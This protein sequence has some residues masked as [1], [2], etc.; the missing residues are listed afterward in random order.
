M[1]LAGQ[2]INDCLKSHKMCT[3]GIS[4]CNT[5]FR[6]TRLIDTQDPGRPFLTTTKDT[7]DMK[8]IVLSYVWG[9]EVFKTK[10]ENVEDHQH[11]IPLERVPKTIAHAFQVTRELGYRYIWVDALCIIQDDDDD[12]EH[13]LAIMG[14]IYRYAVFTVFAEG[15]PGAFAGLF[16]KRDPQSY[17]PC[18]V[19]VKIRTDRGVVSEHLTLGTIA[20]GPNYLKERGWVLQE[21]VLSS[22]CLSFGK[23]ISWKC[24]VSEASETRP[25]PHARKTALTHGRATCEDKLKMW[26]YA[27]VQM[28]ETPREQW[29]RWNQY[30]AWY[31]IVE[32]Y[33]T[34]SL[35]HET[36]HLRA[37]SGLADLF[38]R[39]H[40]SV[41][42]AGLWKDDLKL[43]LAW[44]VA[45]NCS[46]PMKAVGLQKPSWSWA[47]VGMVR[48][49]FRSWRAYSTHVSSEGAEILGASCTPASK[50]NSTGSVVDG[51]LKLRT[52]VKKLTLRWSTEYVADRTEFSH[53]SYFGREAATMTKG[54]HPRFPALVFDL[55]SPAQLLGEAALDRPVRTRPGTG[56]TRCE[57][58]V[59]CALLHV[60][61]SSD[62]LRFTALVLDHDQTAYRRL[63]LLFIDDPHVVPFSDW[64]MQAIDIL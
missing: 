46:R 43:G 59:W 2:W 4:H 35:T 62:K 11:C 30:D 32:E 28:R 47:S 41:Y 57:R 60:Q 3:S 64:R 25:V 54:E 23:Q 15:A 39:A 9:S 44:Y 40:P 24:T 33:S 13:E 17:R 58:E 19:N 52:R 10:H 34:K 5:T 22:R 20:T 50:L 8:Y 61:K 29:F 38:Q 42:V 48:L 16:Q 56:I 6:P 7:V 26:L 18:T 27:P 49:K 53:G 12:L 63:G 14:N 55:E 36:D 37:L 1:E 45:S 31:S 21:G 51:I